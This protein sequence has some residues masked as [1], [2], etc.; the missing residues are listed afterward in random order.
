MFIAATRI[1]NIVA[2]IVCNRNHW[3]SQPKVIDMHLGSHKIVDKNVAAGY[4]YILG[5]PPIVGSFKASA[6]IMVGAAFKD[7]AHSARIDNGEARGKVRNVEWSHKAG[8][9]S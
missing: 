5:M 9:K 7:T 1:T 2:R 3:G 4:I 8:D 6:R